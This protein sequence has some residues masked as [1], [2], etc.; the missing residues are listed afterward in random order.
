[1]K[2]YQIPNTPF[3]ANEAGQI[4]NPK[5]DRILKPTYK[6]KVSETRKRFHGQWT[7]DGVQSKL[8]TSWARI[9][10]SAKLGRPLLPWEDACHVNGDNGDDRM[11]NLEAKSRL[12]NI[13]DEYKIGRLSE[14][15]NYE[16]DKAIAELEALKK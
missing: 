15:P 13:I 11:E 1:M 7:V 9:V 12:R 5:T 6:Y 2:W 16:I 4:R 3:E 10:L 8:T 14:I